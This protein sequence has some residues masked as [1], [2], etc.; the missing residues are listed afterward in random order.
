MAWPPA[1][2][3]PSPTGLA[4]DAAGNLYI[5]DT[6]NSRI[7]MVAASNSYITT[8]STGSDIL[9][10]PKGVA[11]DAAGNVYIAD[12]NNCRIL[13]VTP[14]GSITITTTVDRQRQRCVWL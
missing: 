12:T 6:G 8:L 9:S 14:S 10:S 2:N 3:S 7:R 4:L 11:V 5:A 13:K 1:R